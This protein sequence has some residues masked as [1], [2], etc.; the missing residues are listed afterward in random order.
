MEAYTGFA[1][2]YD[3]FMDNIPYEQ[4]AK[5]VIKLLGNNGVN[6]QIEN[7]SIVDLG[8]GTGTF[9]KI[10]SDAGFQMIGIDNS[11]EM[12]MIASSKKEEIEEIEEIEESEESE[13]CEE[14]EEYEESEVSQGYQNSDSIVYTLQDMRDFAV[15]YPVAAIVSVCDSMNYII[16]EE[17]LSEVFKCVKEA[18]D[19]NGVFIFDM[20]TQ[21]F[22]RDI[23]GES[24]I[25]E[26]R[27]N[28]AFIWENYYYEE[29]SINEYEMTIF[30]EEEKGLFR[31]Y[32]ETHIQ[33]GYTI[34]EVKVSLAVSG[35]E[36]VNIYDAFTQ[37]PP[38]KNSERIYFV[39]KGKIGN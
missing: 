9:T 39:V 29:E 38:T 37:N 34:E 15:P 32:E 36:I 5:Y 12:L 33:R 21:H 24:T 7:P 22:Y 17:E 10:L 31:K 20:K 2:V 8:C 28:A 14:I 19:E 13:E 18:L 23:L 25:A 4:W 16:E 1:E 27:E 30:I 11:Q 35:L 6:A 3:I 26:N